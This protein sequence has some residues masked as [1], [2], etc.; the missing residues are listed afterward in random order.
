MQGKYEEL[1]ASEE[2]LS[3]YQ[4]TQLD[5]IKQCRLL[6]IDLNS[7]EAEE[8]RNTTDANNNLANASN[9]NFNKDVEVMAANSN[10][11]NLPTCVFK[12]LLHYRY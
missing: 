3:F 7:K 6:N 1:L 2:P 4:K 5:I 12:L 9:T 8:L 10:R 11:F